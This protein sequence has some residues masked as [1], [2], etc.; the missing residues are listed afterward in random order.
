MLVDAIERLDKAADEV[1]IQTRGKLMQQ[2]LLGETDAW[3]A[4]KDIK[5]WEQLKELKEL[6]DEV[7]DVQ[8]KEQFD[9]AGQVTLFLRSFVGE[10]SVFPLVQVRLSLVEGACTLDIESSDRWMHDSCINLKR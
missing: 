2:Y 6:E 1:V 5:I 7:E 4:A 9:H 10:L 3:H 8:P